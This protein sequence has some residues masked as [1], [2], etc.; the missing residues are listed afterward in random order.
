M[1]PGPVRVSVI[2]PT[3]DRPDWLRQSLTSIHALA[4][5]DL[6]FEV[7]VSDDS[8]RSHV[9]DIARE[10]GARVVRPVTRGAAGARNAGLRAATG[11]FIA[12]L[13]DDD[14]WLPDHLRPHLALLQ[15]D[16]ELGGVVSQVRNGDAALSG[17]GPPWPVRVAGGADRFR[18]FYRYF[19][20]IGATVVRRS[21]IESVGY[22][23]ETLQGAEDWDWH[24]RLALAHRVA[25][26]PVAS[27]GYRMRPVG[28]DD[29]LIMNRLPFHRRV[30]WSNALR[31]GRRALPP[32]S[33]VRAWLRHRGEFAGHLLASATLRERSGDVAGAQRAVGQAFMASPAH[34]VRAL[35]GSSRLRGVMVP[36]RERRAPQAADPRRR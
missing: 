11:D 35:V 14:V 15:A 26:V 19:P 31:A 1:R 7:I 10:F 2:V 24:L 36:G 9:A 22:Q 20:Q 25:F 4:G 32:H 29:D 27:V 5:R 28:T 23:D 6:E 13:D 34:C 16:P 21:A 3:H 33:L 30:F 17:L 12:F 8:E 18:D